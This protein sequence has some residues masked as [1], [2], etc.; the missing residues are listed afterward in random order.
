MKTLLLT[1]HA[2]TEQLPLKSSK[3]DFERELKPRGHTDSELV[4][5][6]MLTRQ[7]Q[8]QLLIS[9]K[10]M[11]AKQTALIFAERFGIHKKDIIFEQFLYDGYTAGELLG[12]LQPFKQKYHS[13]MVV[14][15]NPEIEMAATKLTGSDELH[16]PTTGTIAISFNV[17]SWQ[18]VK[19]AKGNIEWFATP[20]MLK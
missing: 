19:G 8:P 14:G 4:A 3:S 15:H 20:K 5:A 16:F 10:A 2:K 13:I 6:D 18:D 7:I 1:R 9:S 11:R 12:Y 17:D